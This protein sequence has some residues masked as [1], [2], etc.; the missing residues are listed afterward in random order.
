[1]RT[2]S[3]LSRLASAAT[4]ALA[5]L[6]AATVSFAATDFRA[7]VTWEPSWGSIG[8]RI[9]MKP[10]VADWDAGTDVGMPPL[11]GD[12]TMAWTVV[13][14]LP[15]VPLGGDV[16]FRVTG[17]DATGVESDASNEITVDEATILAA[18]TPVDLSLD[19]APWLRVAGTGTWVTVPAEPVDDLPAEALQLA[20]TRVP[21]T[22]FGIGSTVAP[23]ASD[24]SQ[25]SVSL[26]VPVGGSFLVQALVRD[27]LGRHRKVAWIPGAGIAY[28]ERNVPT[29]PLGDGLVTGGVA[30]FTRDLAADLQAGLGM[31]FGLLEQVQVFGG[32][33]LRRVRLQLE[34]AGGFTSDP[35]GTSAAA[36]TT[37]WRSNTKTNVVQGLYDP[38]LG[39]E[40]IQA[41]LVPGQTVPKVQYPYKSSVKMIA[42]FRQLNV[43]TQGFEEFS[44]EAQI[45]L[46][47]GTRYKMLFSQAVDDTNEVVTRSQAK[48]PMPTPADV[49]G[50]PWDALV[51]RL[52]TEFGV[53][54]SNPA[55]RTIVPTSPYSGIQRLTI[56]GGFW[57]GPVAF[58]ERVR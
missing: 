3:I 47:D 36:P 13:W 6:A 42:P 53:L 34:G 39:R 1:M 41:T 23:S 49:P 50:S 56:R 21:P 19:A 17:Y 38:D 16:S 22:L 27:D 7:R 18:I 32:L 52:A 4:V 33:D 48:L 25:L 58:E 8:Y 44:V 26:A 54:Q 20:T 35:P 51:L 5:V 31:Q 45:V 14:T 30:S 15:A 28:L 10:G 11:Q 24:R 43:P 40:T 55:T 2:R 9:Y 12:G 29:F 46:E 57:I 37:G